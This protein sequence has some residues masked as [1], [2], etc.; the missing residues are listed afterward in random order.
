[1]NGNKNVFQ[2]YSLFDYPPTNDIGTNTLSA[3]WKGLRDDNNIRAIF[4]SPYDVN[5]Q[6]IRLGGAAAMGSAS[7][8][9]LKGYM[10]GFNYHGGLASHST[11]TTSNNMDIWL[12]NP[13]SGFQNGFSTVTSPPLTSISSNDLPDPSQNFVKE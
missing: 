2:P 4:D 7:H 3:P 8:T 10:N 1:M 5:A 6:D 12:N 9:Q 11:P 13:R